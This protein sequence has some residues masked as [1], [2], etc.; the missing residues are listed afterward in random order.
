MKTFAVLLT[1]IFLSL[2]LLAQDS[3]EF[4]FSGTITDRT[5]GKPIADYMV[6][7]F[8][9][10]TL[11]KSIPSE[12][13]GRFTV[14][15]EGSETY[16]IEISREA[17]YPKR[18]MILTNIPTDVKK[19]PEF[20]FEMELIRTDEYID[21]EEV[22]PYATSIF[23]FPYVIFEYDASISDLNYR[24]EYTEHIKDEYQAVEDLR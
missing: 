23:D 14:I 16:L 24:K 22:D 18:A 15:L 6:D 19:L 9:G 1:F 20:K 8:K 13:K 7:V 17:Y 2:S 10:N 11:I 21:L 3:R 4:K 5:D 12:K